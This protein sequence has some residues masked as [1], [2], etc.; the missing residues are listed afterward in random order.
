MPSKIEWKNIPSFSSLN[1]LRE[2][3]ENKLDR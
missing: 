2:E 3:F 1:G